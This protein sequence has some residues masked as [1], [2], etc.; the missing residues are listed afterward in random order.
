MPCDN[1]LLKRDYLV[2]TEVRVEVGLDVLEQGDRA[3]GTSTSDDE[4]RSLAA[5]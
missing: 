5:A 4:R 3:V 1:R 2:R